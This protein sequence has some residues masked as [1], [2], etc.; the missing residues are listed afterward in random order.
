MAKRL[1]RNYE[2]MTDS[3]LQSLIHECYRR[4]RQLKAPYSKG[5][6]SWKALRA[7]VAAELARRA[8]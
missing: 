2:T 8:G 6:R 5:R 1:V 7:E 3:E 4:E